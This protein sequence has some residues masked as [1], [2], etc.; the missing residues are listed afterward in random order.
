LLGGV[1]RAARG[2]TDRNDVLCA[3]RDDGEDRDACRGG[4]CDEG[5]ASA[6]VP[7][8]PSE[9][10]EDE[11]S[12]RTSGEDGSHESPVGRSPWELTSLC[13]WATVRGV[14][15]SSRGEDAHRRE[16]RMNAHEIVNVRRVDNAPSTSR[17]LISPRL[18]LLHELAPIPFQSLD[19]A[20]RRRPGG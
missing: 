13:S 1:D 16:V 18:V 9:D 14:G 7:E 20:P 5:Q 17:R 2:G 15:E 19:V 11:G 6:H 10:D 3:R 12:E 8:P 4:G